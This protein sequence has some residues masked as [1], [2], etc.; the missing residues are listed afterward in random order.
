MAG[1]AA[2]AARIQ[3][4]TKRYGDHA[5]LDGVDLDIA[6][7]ERRG[8]LGL[9]GAGKTTLLRTLF[10]LVEA[11]AGSIELLG[12]RTGAGRRPALSGVDGFVEDPRFYSIP[13]CRDGPTWSSG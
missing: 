7:G 11:D 1:V 8:L 6:P 3:G 13:T 9:N 4:L 2:S 10:G 5:A 12:R